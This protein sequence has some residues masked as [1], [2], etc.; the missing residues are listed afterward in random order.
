LKKN[1][2]NGAITLEMIKGSLAELRNKHNPI[3]GNELN[4]GAQSAASKEILDL[5]NSARK[6]LNDSIDKKNLDKITNTSKLKR[7]HSVVKRLFGIDSTSSKNL[8]SLVKKLDERGLKTTSLDKFAQE[9]KSGEVKSTT[10]KSLRSE[11]ENLQKTVKV[12]PNNKKNNPIKLINKAIDALKSLEVGKSETHRLS[13]LQK[14]AGPA[15]YL[16][17][18]KTHQKLLLEKAVQTK[19]IEKIIG[20]DSVQNKN[21]GKLSS[22]NLSRISAFIKTADLAMESRNNMK[23]ISDIENILGK[24]AR[25]IIAETLIESKGNLKVFEKKMQNVLEAKSD[26][27]VQRK[28][29]ESK[30]LEAHKQPLMRSDSVKS[31]DKAQSQIKNLVSEFQETERILSKPIQ[32]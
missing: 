25:K 29:S 30:S 11:L 15:D 2:K 28:E 31:A 32:K 21:L 3:M 17:N 10:I 4:P 18:T 8:N 5:L 13:T 26:E 12:D 24:D 27:F 7:S 1:I 14:K 16:L 22:E 9:L 20:K 6:I 19:S 23:T